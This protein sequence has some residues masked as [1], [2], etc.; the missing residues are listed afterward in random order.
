MSSTDS[1]TIVLIHGLWLTPRSWE[2]WVQRYTSQGHRVLAPAWPGLEGE[3]ESL[4][5]D[6]RPLEGLTIRRVLDHYERII[7]GLD[8]LPIIMGHSFGGLFTQILIDRG[9]GAAGV[10]IS[11]G[12]TAGVLTLPLD[13]LRTGWPVLGNPFNYNRAVPLTPAQFNWRFTNEL[14]PAESKPVYDRYYV[15]AAGRVFFDGVLALT[16]PNSVTRVNYRNPRRAP[17]LFIA[18]SNDHVVPASVNRA[19]VKKYA[20]SGAV[21][22]YREFAGRT[23]NL[24]NGAGWEEVADYALDWAVRHTGSRASVSAGPAPLSRTA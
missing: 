2:K 3:V 7:R 19:N 21:T 12:Q 24:V 15:P 16:A 17:M 22:E 13:T 9:L 18:G 8:T 23:H 14:S 6:P 10:P 11:A 5:R 20:G 1:R 4:R